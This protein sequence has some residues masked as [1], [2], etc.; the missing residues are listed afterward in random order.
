MSKFK[1]RSM[2]MEKK[3][4]DAKKEESQ[5]FDP[6]ACQPKHR[7]DDHLEMYNN[8]IGCLQDYCTRKADQIY[9]NTIYMLNKSI[10]EFIYEIQDTQTTI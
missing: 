4:I 10:D 9:D 2:M 7:Q 6:V 1:Q 5:K 8:I 3:A